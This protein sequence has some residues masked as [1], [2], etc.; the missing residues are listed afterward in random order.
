VAWEI[1]GLL[2]ELSD[3]KKQGFSR[4]DVETKGLF[5]A[6][7]KVKEMFGMGVYYRIKT[8]I[9][10][11][12]NILQSLADNPKIKLFLYTSLNLKIAEAILDRLHLSNFFNAESRRSC[13]DCYNESLKHPT[14]VDC[15]TKRVI[16]VTGTHK[17]HIEEDSKYFLVIK[18]K[19]L[20]DSI[21]V[22][23][24]I[25]A[26]NCDIDDLHN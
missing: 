20:S 22:L 14:E 17:D 26:K 1:D 16:I 2:V 3:R 4:V 9:K 15:N 13:S 18:K 10:N 23:N 12:K 19:E 25:I 6:V 24:R 7:E 11:M 21:K 8:S 5:Y